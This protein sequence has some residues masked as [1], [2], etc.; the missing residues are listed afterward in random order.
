MVVMR[1][2]GYVKDGWGK[3]NDKEVE[4]FLKRVKKAV[5]ATID[6]YQHNYNPVEAY[7]ALRWL[8]KSFETEFD[9]R[10]MGEI[11]EIA[12][13]FFKPRRGTHVSTKKLLVAISTALNAQYIPRE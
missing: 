13:E 8:L 6:L 2:E 7:V 5:Y 11:K 10:G 3:M 4:A 1:V 12:D 9:R